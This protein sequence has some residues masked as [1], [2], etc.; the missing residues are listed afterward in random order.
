MTSTTST[1]DEQQFGFE[2][3][4]P[5]GYKNLQSSTFRTVKNTTTSNTEV[6]DMEIENLNNDYSALE[7]IRRGISSMFYG[8]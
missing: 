2:Y 6:V 3:G 1:I 7:S 5:S 4:K 8:E